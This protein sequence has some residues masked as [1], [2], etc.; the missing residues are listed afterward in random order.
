MKRALLIAALA[1]AAM[2]PSTAAAQTATPQCSPA[3]IDCA[4]W[5]AVDVDLKWTVDAPY[6]EDCNNFRFKL[7]GISQRTCLVSNDNV[8][9]TQVPV[10]VRVDKTPP[11]VEG[12][13]ASRGPDANGWYRSPVHV[14][15]FGTD[16]VP[17]V[18]TSGIAGCSAGTYS[19][20]DAASAELIGRCWDVAG[21]VSAP[22][23]FPLRYD[24]TAPSITTL[25]A[26]GGDHTARVRWA[27]SGA[28]DVVVSRSPGRNGAAQSV[29]ATNAT[30]RVRDRGLRNGRRYRYRVRAVDQAGNA[31]E[32]QFSVVPGRR[33]VAPARRA[34]LTAPPLLRWT[35]VDGAR[36]YNVQL[37]RN[38]RKILSVWPG[39]ARY[40]L[41]RSWRYGGER[42]RLKPGTY[43]WM[44]WPGRGARANSDYGPLI[45]RRSF[46]IAP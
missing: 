40:Q 23:A 2:V 3:P 20:P 22:R 11:R 45:G 15:F 35:A 10:T 7:D 9:W 39:R 29:V 28:T 4:G 25:A 5:Y 43:R 17:N 33:L 21:N 30:G 37:F 14:T 31:S 12:T 32:R 44:V 1:L 8:K 18:D 36:Y 46:T 19:G 38:G 16:V 6:S 13:A 27:V 26:S 34:R 42:R 41:E 24:A